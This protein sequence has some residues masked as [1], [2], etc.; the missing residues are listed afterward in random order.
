MKSRSNAFCR[1][2]SMHSGKRYWRSGFTL[3]ELLVVVAIISVI[4]VLIFPAFKKGVES[5]KTAKCVGNLKGIGSGMLAYVADH[6]GDFPPGAQLP[7]GQYK[8][9]FRQ[10]T[11]WFDA[12]N[13]YMGYPEYAADRTLPF[14]AAD[15]VGT[16]FPFAWQQCPAKVVKPLQRQT[17]G[18]GW[19]ISNFG[20]DLSA[21]KRNP[22]VTGFGSRISQVSQPSKTIIIGDSKDAGVRAEN[23]FE[24]R[25]IYD[26]GAE[27]RVPYPERHGGGGNYLFVDGHVDWFSSEAMKTTEV[28]ALFKRTK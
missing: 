22:G 20:D 28:R 23:T 17:V 4:A 24:D 18:Y 21:E 7:N 13:P 16:E 1:D 3:I 2:T 6:D 12:L 11:F 8:I 14:P 19:N 25:Y 27:K 15:S 5:S 10:K 26:Y 9:T